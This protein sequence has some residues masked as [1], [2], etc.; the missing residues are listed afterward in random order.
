MQKIFSNK[1]FWIVL[2][3]VLLI[4]S[5]VSGVYLGFLNRPEVARITSLTHTDLTS[6]P[7]QKVDFDPFWKVWNTL[8][9]KF[10]AVSTTSDAQ[11]GDQKR[12]WGAIAGLTASL[13]D[14][15]TVFFPP[16]ESKSFATEISGSFSGVGMEV[17]VR[18]GG[19]VVVAPLK[20]SPSE[21]AGIRTGD[22]ILKIDGQTADGLAVDKAVK[23]IRGKEGTVVVLTVTRE[24]KNEP[25][26]IKITRAQIE[27]PTIKTETKGGTKDGSKDSLVD[28]VFIIHLYNFSAIS[29]NLF[30][31]ALREF[32]VTN[33]NKLILDVR[34][35]PGG[36]LDAAVDMASWFLP[37]GKVIVTEDFGKKA[38]PVVYKSKG[39][40]V[41]GDK[42]KMVVLI[43]GGSASA[44]EILA[45]AL[46][47]NGIATL[48]GEKSFGKGS[49]QEL[50][51]ITPETSLKVTVARWLTPLGNSISHAGINPDIV[52][53]FTQDDATKGR[54]PQLERAIKFLNTGK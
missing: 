23:M 35:N 48:V 29:S 36:Y 18:D 10:V 3:V 37:S 46:K 17:G 38:E 13:N 39:Y 31:D 33:S 27:I 5:F 32:V 24:S 20:G 9:D 45:G 21:K 44:S 12:V 53:K 43:N 16:E 30:R 50:V 47:E 11:I 6:A 19:L 51:K 4:A 28:G 1:I 25:F 14:P 2:G 41:F 49:V 26:D 54:D 7:T 52:V 22:R 40:N 8:N 42:L 34:G 15:Y